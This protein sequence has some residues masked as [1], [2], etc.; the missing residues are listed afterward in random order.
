MFVRRT[1]TVAAATVGILA[2][3]SGTAF[4]HQCINISKNPSAGVQ[5]V[6]DETT[7]EVA[8]ISKGLQQ[9]IEQGLVDFETGEGF[10][11][12]IGFDVDGDGKADAATYILGPTGEIPQQAQW[13]GAECKGMV[14]FEAL[15]TCPNSPL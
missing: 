10:S 1:A 6:F 11:G 13:N 7:G 12:L 14:N 4:A 5:L 8:W 9:R 2:V 3:G 15:F